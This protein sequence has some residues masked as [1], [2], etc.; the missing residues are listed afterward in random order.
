[1]A[2]RKVLLVIKQYN[3][4]AQSSPRIGGRPSWLLATLART[5]VAWAFS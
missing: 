5:V 2:S 1:M 3:S 4:I